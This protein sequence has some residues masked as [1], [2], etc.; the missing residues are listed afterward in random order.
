L[1]DISEAENVLEKFLLSKSIERDE[2][3]RLD[4]TD[5]GSF[6]VRIE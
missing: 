4:V 2:R 3:Y 5:N 6:W 1:S